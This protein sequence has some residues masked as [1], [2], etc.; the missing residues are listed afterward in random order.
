MGRTTQAAERNKRLKVVRENRERKLFRVRQQDEED[1]WDEYEKANSA[2]SS[3]DS[4]GDK[5]SPDEPSSDEE[6]LE[7]EGDR[8]NTCEGLG[9]DEDGGAQLD[10]CRWLSSRS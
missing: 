3:D 7:E 8:D 6:N 4:I 1:F 9:D 2:F 10:R 5:S